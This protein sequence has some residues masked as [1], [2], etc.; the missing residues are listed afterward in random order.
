[1]LA[2]AVAET[3]AVEQ[4]FLENDMPLLPSEGARCCAE[5]PAHP[6]QAHPL[7]AQVHPLPA[8]STLPP[9]LPPPGLP[10]HEWVAVVIGAAAVALVS[11]EG[12]ESERDSLLEELR[13]WKLGAME[14]AMF[15]D[16]A[17]EDAA[18]P[19]CEPV[20]PPRLG[21][22]GSERSVLN[23]VTG[24]ELHE[25]ASGQSPGRIVPA[26]PAARPPRPAPSR[27]TAGKP[28]VSPRSPAQPPSLPGA[29]AFV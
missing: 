7:A 14:A 20:S 2:E 27:P 11:A 9:V 13:A 23:C 21:R 29:C 22:A 1:M 19:V 6:S 8:C 24:E 10:Q 25:L 16:S 15:E 5:L 26:P 28:K 4:A 3:E 17:L 18:L 12:P